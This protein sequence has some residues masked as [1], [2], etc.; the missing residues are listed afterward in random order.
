M[1]K[2]E[3]ARGQSGAEGTA[4]EEVEPLAITA[5]DQLYRKFKTN[6]QNKGRKAERWKIGIQRL[7]PDPIKGF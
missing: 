7:M 4:Q 6:L 1:M 3:R 2:K 5:T